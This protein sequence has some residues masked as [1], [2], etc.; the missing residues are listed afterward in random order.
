MTLV[1][2][3]KRTA[4][5]GDVLMLQPVARALKA[6]DGGETVIATDTKIIRSL[7]GPPLPEI[8]RLVDAEHLDRFI[9][10]RG[11]G[12]RVHDMNHPRHSLQRGHQID[13]FLA[14]LDFDP[15]ACDKS[16]RLPANPKAQAMVDFYLDEAPEPE[17]PIGR[18]LLHPASGAMNRT[19]PQAKWQGLADRLSAAQVQV[20]VIGN[21]SAATGKGAFAL[22]VDSRLDVVDK[23]GFWE[24]IEL[25][26]LSDCLVSTDSAPV[27]MAAAT[28]IRIAGIYSITRGEW[29][30]PF[31][32]EG[33]AKAIEPSCRFF[34]CYPLMYEPEHL[35][36]ARAHF[37]A[38][39]VP[40]QNM[41]YE[42]CCD[43]YSYDCLN[44]DM[45]VDA[46]FEA[47][48]SLLPSPVSP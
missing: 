14:A 28:A 5:L 17:H 31:R 32:A 18:V 13:S 6:R 46:V 33:V 3:L 37:D 30:L 10:E 44:R 16:I 45:A 1:H 35:G 41:L 12:V 8:D 22:E 21:R 11:D 36:K 43:D 23:F 42:W 20:F 38:I 4:G 39:R 7:D 26:R 24:T 48:M 29:R 25:M 47:V 34:P 2:V 40:Q 19:W 27:Q 15:A 9:A